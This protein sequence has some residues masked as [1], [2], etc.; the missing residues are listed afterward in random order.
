MTIEERPVEGEHVFSC[1][2][3]TEHQTWSNA[4]ATMA[5]AVWHVFTAHQS[6]WL[7]VAGNRGPL[8]PMPEALGT[9]IS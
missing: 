2:L 8:D 7:Q 4:A 6:T 1:N 3:C 5:A 9:R